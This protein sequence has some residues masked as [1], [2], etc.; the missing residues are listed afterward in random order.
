MTYS[1]RHLRNTI[2]LNL[3][4]SGLTQ[5]QI[6]LAVGLGQQAVSHI[7]QQASQGLPIGKKH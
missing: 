7:I 1:E 3:A 5:Q 4:E 6:G 2:L